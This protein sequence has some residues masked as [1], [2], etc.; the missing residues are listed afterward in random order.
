[1]QQ[2]WLECAK[3]LDACGVLT[4]TLRE[5]LQKNSLTLTVLAHGLRDGVILCNLIETLCP[6]STDPTQIVHRTQSRH[7]SVKNIKKFLSACKKEFQLSDQELFQAE[8]LYDL[9][10]E[11]A[12]RALSTISKLKQVE[13]KFSRSGFNI[14]SC[15]N[16]IEDYYNI[17]SV[18]DHELPN[19]INGNES[20]ND[21]AYIYFTTTT[22]NGC[23]SDCDDGQINVSKRD[24]ITLEIYESE[25]HFVKTLEIIVYDFI[26]KLVPFIKD[27]DNKQIFLN[28]E[29]IRDLH[30]SIVQKLRE[31]IICL[32]G[33][34]SRICA[35]YDSFKKKLTK[36]YALFQAGVEQAIKKIKILN[37]QSSEFRKKVEECRKKSSMVFFHLSDLIQIP[38]ERALKY[39][40]L[41][42][43]LYINTCDQDQSKGD[44]ER[45][46][47]NMKDLASYLERIQNNK[48]SLYEIRKEYGEKTD[49]FYTPQ[50]AILNGNDADYETGGINNG[51]S[52]KMSNRDLVIREIYE[53]EKHF[54]EKLYMIINDFMKPLSSVLSESDRKI[55]FINFD[56]LIE[57]HFQLLEK[58]REA[59]SGGHGRTSRICS[60][61]DSFRLYIMNGYVDYFGGIQKSLLKLK[62]L[63]LN[64]VEFKNKLSECRKKSEL[65]IFE[66]ADLIRLPYQRVL[67]YHL[68]FAELNKNT[69]ENHFAKRDIDHTHSGML[70]VAHYL[71]HAQ[72]DQEI[73]YQIEDI[74]NH[75]EEL[76]S[77]SKSFGHLIK[78]DNVRIK[79]IGETFSKTRILLLFDKALLICK[80]TGDNYH[81]KATI[82]LNE[83]KLESIESN[84]NTK[85]L[86]SNS[87]QL[88][89]LFA[90]DRSKGYT[91]TF[92]DYKQR[93][94][95]RIAI[96]EAI[97]KLLP[98]G[99]NSNGHNFILFNFEREIVN[100]FICEKVLLGILYQGYKCSKC[101]SIAH[102]SC[103]SKFQQC[104]ASKVVTRTSNSNTV[105]RQSV[106][107]QENYRRTP[108]FVAYRVRALYPY[109]GRPQPPDDD[110]ILK[111][112][113]GDII[114]VIDDDDNDWWKG[115][116]VDNK[117]TIEEGWF[118]KNNVKLIHEN[119]KSIAV[120]NKH[121][122]IESESWYLDCNRDT[123]ETILKDSPVIANLTPFLVRPSEKGGFAIS[124]RFQTIKH[125]RIHVLKHLTQAGRQAEFVYLD[126]KINFLSVQELIA[127]FRKKNLNDDDP[128]LKTKLN[129]SFRN[130]LLIKEAVALID[131]DPK[132][133][134][135]GMHI[136]LVKNQKYWLIR[137]DAEFSEVYNTNGRSGFVPTNYLKEI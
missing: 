42:D 96:S 134:T 94:D 72:R 31:A 127:H 106:H 54:V 129:I 124:F 51:T 32:D 73:I 64:S 105:F 75:L 130:A 95:W 82:F 83:Y 111:F 25:T 36:E 50:E 17:P 133:D 117:P 39:H 40:L 69:S 77:H 48:E 81:N 34:T 87:V 68:L 99:Y 79:E 13:Q 137:K 11:H 86:N 115:F 10:I 120:E 56:L 60:V 20:N 28:I 121:D 93:N 110:Q 61:Y 90:N 71:D 101:S 100:C 7:A 4:E 119:S 8:M 3:W 131:Y 47:F 126:E 108:K 9:Y 65:G 128:K 29:S 109:D 2:S 80:S 123:A 102:R 15:Q 1:M 52:V 18:D 91:L 136:Q 63:N 112:K 66:I 35:V 27:S 37:S 43:E 57:I 103:I 59:I 116:K 78:D 92:K 70:E 89:L 113:A 132:P 19:D 74:D 122:S 88:N 5:Q 97:D 6:G 33:R 24:L 98:H 22:N 107:V 30:L 58:L 118:P 16:E 14:N 23:Y 41:F 44:I 53:S 46:Y 84:L 76:N 45:T 26:K 125:I 114:Q 135:V 12:I 85:K 38:L 55:I 67:K 49:E 21:D 104:S 62:N